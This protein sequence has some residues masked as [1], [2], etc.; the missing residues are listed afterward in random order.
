MTSSSIWPGPATRDNAL[1]QLSEFLPQAGSDYAALR[2]YDLKDHPHVS[3]LSP[4]LRHRILTE[5][6]VLRTVLRSYDRDTAQKFVDE[7]LWRTYWKGWLEM[8]PGVWRDYRLGV[9]AALNRIQTESGLRSEWEA[10]CS[11]RTEIECFNIWARQL[12]HDGYLHNHARMW[13]ASI[14]IF[15]L[16]LPWELGA[17]FFLRHLYD[18]DPA[19][20]TLSW[21]WVAGLQTRGKAYIAE[22]WN[23]EKFT[24]GRVPRPEDLAANPAPLDGPPSPD[25]SSLDLALE[26]DMHCPT[27]L[28]ITE[29]D[30]SPSDIF[31]ETDRLQAIAHY[32]ATQ[33]RSPLAVSPHVVSFVSDAIEACC[34]SLPGQ[35]T[36][37]PT[38]DEVV[39]WAIAHDLKQ[40]VT[41]Y[42][43]V[44][45]T[46]DALAALEPRLEDAGIALAR[47][48]RP[49]DA[50]AWPRARAGYFK[51]RKTSGSFL[52]RLAQ[53]A[54]A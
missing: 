15:T 19:S 37:C 43:P 30:L 53:D 48:A 32:H 12:T 23:I 3:R 38:P 20:N 47:I 34:A 26:W 1:R 28:L 5:D 27:G 9:Q 35:A 50:D 18:G 21:R 36:H 44:G 6:E 10:A 16:R 13:F 45:P 2:G 29:E 42:P 25:P 52:E 40:I 24:K 49:Y 41:A 54:A 17:D 46:A 31:P 8:R 33:D 7:V 14:W 51:F 22:A 11:G 39:T 4:F